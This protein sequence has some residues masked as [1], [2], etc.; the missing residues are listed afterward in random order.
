M[1]GEQVLG[2]WKLVSDNGMFALFDEIGNNLLAIPIF[3]LFMLTFCE[4]ERYSFTK[5]IF[6][7]LD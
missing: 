1:P 7:D 2:R 4:I 6:N 5:A 3:T